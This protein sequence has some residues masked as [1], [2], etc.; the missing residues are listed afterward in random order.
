MSVLDI[1]KKINYYFEEICKIPHGSYQEE[2]LA[3]YLIAFA[4]S[5]QLSYF[6]DDLHNVVIFKEAA[7]GYEKKE[8][9]LLQAHI[10]MVNE[11]ESDSNHNFNSDPLSLY[12]EDGW[13]HAQKTTLG[14]D[15]GVGVAYMLAL[16]DDT[17]ALHPALECVF[18]VQEEV[19]LKGAAYLDTSS[20]KASRMINLDCETEGKTC[21]SS[22]G[23]TDEIVSKAFELEEN[24]KPAYQLKISGLLGG[25]SG[26][27]IHKGKANAIKLLA[28]I[29]YH[30]KKDDILIQLV[31][32]KG[33][34]KKNAIPRDASCIF[35]T[36]AQIEDIVE[37]INKSFSS[38]KREY[39][40]TDPNITIEL[41]QL[42]CPVCMGKNESEEWIDYLYLCVNGLIEMSQKIPTLP[43]LS[44][45]LGIMETKDDEII[46]HY[47]I[48]SP[49]QSKRLEICEQLEGLSRLCKC[50][51]V[52]DNDHDGWTSDDTSPLRNAFKA[53]Y[54][55]KTGREII[56]YA[57]HGGLE[58]GTL[59]GKMPQLDIITLGPTVENIHS[60][61]ER[62][63]LA[64]FERV[65]D[66]LKEFL[67]KL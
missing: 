41:A 18:T 56:E 7:K 17:N 50:K 38:I 53:F 40:E 11:K 64:S 63:N 60:P 15:D 36:N 23:V 26:N 8:S 58:T 24:S 16:L 51:A 27:Q 31:D 44:L 48:R 42:T 37:S 21:I 67:E 9:I 2:K 3:D 46:C 43:Y 66:L 55:E 39:R 20:L 57:T 14:G 52:R 5:H 29:L 32:I 13:L 47:H 6:S 30:L 65:Y 12:V 25:H 33:G 54:R 22:A 4:K 1:S 19:G 28:R 62:L 61:Q 35:C 49:Q 45:N 10:D 34:S 59:K